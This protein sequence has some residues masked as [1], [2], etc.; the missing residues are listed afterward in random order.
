PLQGYVAS[1]DWPAS[2]F[3]RELADE[4][5]N[6]IVLLS[7]RSSAETWWGSVDSTIMR[8]MRGEANQMDPEWTGMVTTLFG[9]FGL[10]DG[11]PEGG[12]AAYERHNEAVR[13]AILPGRL[14]EWHPG[15]GWEPICSALGL[16]VPAEPFPHLNTR[17]E[18]ISGR[19]ASDQD[20]T[21]TP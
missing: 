15:D 17:E 16:P 5:P 3:W 21:G 14:V 9:D 20:E 6:A 18:W 2:A 11:D 19:S 13:A 12:M 10:R 7:M 1:V 8:V 4:N